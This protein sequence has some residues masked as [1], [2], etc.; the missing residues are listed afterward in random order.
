MEKN[1]RA[2][3]VG[4]GAIGPVHAQMLYE[5][6]GAQ[7]LGVCDIV[8]ERTQNLAAEYH[9]K[10]Y[11]SYAQ[12]LAD[13]EVDVVHICTPHYL[14]APMAREAARHGKH[15]VIEKPFAMN[16]EEAEALGAE[17]S[18]QQVK[19]CCVLQNR[20]TPCMQK[21]K[22][23]V[24]SG[25]YGAVM[26]GRGL[27]TWQRTADYYR[28]GA[29]R[30]RWETEGGGLLINQAVH[31]L[32]LLTYVGGECASLV[33]TI[34]NRTLQDVIEVED[35]AEATLYTKKGKILHFFATNGY[36]ANTP[37]DLEIVL[38]KAMLRF[39]NNKLYLQQ[40]DTVE[41]V[42]SNKSTQTGKA[43]W[44][45]GHRNL[46]QAFYRALQ[47]ESDDYTSIA[48]GVAAVRLVDGIYQSAKTGKRVTL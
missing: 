26:G 36:C 30:G 43:Y 18:V 31:L 44:G 24:D 35:T 12:V 39:Q 25:D 27:L 34:A 2:V 22:E 37:F 5:C 32:D 16:R 20:Y 7:L 33:G 29:W 42:A 14:H 9:C 23:I 21:M 4:C 13:P 41:E 19:I 46:I 38:E 45:N 6:Q 15:L 40:G 11:D 17:L 48:Q 47:G 1:K 28:S 8:G 3:V 10:T